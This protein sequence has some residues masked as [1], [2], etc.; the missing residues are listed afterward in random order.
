MTSRSDRRSAQVS[1]RPRR[2]WHRQAWAAGGS[3][4]RRTCRI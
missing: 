3:R 4:A 2:S 1:P